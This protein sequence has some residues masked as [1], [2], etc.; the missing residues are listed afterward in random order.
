MEAET[1]RNIW[2]A[3][4]W[5]IP[6]DARDIA[7]EAGVDEERTAET[8]RNAVQI[9]RDAG[10]PIVSGNDGFQKTIDPRKIVAC[11][12]NMKARASTIL[13]RSNSLLYRITE[14][15]TEEDYQKRLEGYVKNNG[16]E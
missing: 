3:I 6:R 5:D 12:M 9:M 14:N 15:M 7:E 4:W 1:I 8:V 10:L 13:D 11:S 16:S 2:D